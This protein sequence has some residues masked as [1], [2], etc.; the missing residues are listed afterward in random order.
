MSAEY[1]LRDPERIPSPALLFYREYID[2]NIQRMLAVAGHA[3]RLRPHAK[4]HKCPQITRMELAYGITKH[5]CATLAEAEMLARCGV[6]DV[7]IAYP[8]VGPNQSRLG[9]LMA[10]Y[11]QTKFA[12]LADH[13][14]VLASLGAT[15]QQHSVTA[16]VLLDVNV[17]QDRTGVA[18]EHGISLYGTLVQT[19]G[20]RP[21]GLHIYDGH[22]Y[23]ADKVIRE[24]TVKKVL[25]QVL[26][27]REAILQQG[28]PLPR[29]V[30]GGT[31]PFLLYA[32]VDLPELECSPG[33]C[34]LHDANYVRDYPEQGFLP[35]ALVLTRVVSRPTPNRVTFDLGT[36]AVCA[37]PPA[38]K[39][40][41][42]LGLENATAVTHN[43]EHLVLETP[44]AEKWQ[45]GDV[46]YAIPAHV[47]PT[48][49]LH[50]W[51]HVVENGKVVDKW[52]IAARDRE[53]T[54]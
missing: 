26:P 47:C 40:C 5:K 6:P 18:P 39:R 11:P 27:F 30:F 42:V 44:E 17:G 23:A 54:I 20:L 46:A 45:P 15:L 43:E 53:V 38:G 48:V 1:H 33:T 10:A 31:P 35:A 9:K 50:R 22:N 14:G 16:E 4:T 21:G 12:V 32:G 36:K 41:V 19:P 51:A 24:Q 25:A 52:E 3:E 28:W 7:L 34:V 2:R 29:L 8:M 13:P 49:A 37:D